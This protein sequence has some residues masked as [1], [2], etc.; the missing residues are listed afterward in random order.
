[1]PSEALIFAKDSLETGAQPTKLR[2]MLQ[3][4]FDTHL[5]S[6]DLINIKQ[7]LTGKLNLKI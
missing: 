2:M 6:K 3:E 5:I 1:M 7:S 4:K